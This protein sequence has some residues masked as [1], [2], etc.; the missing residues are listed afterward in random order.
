MSLV[1]IRHNF[2][3]LVVN[4]NIRNIVYRQRDKLVTLWNKKVR[5]IL[6]LFILYSGRKITKY[7]RIIVCFCR[8][9]FKLFQSSFEVF[10]DDWLKKI[11]NAV[12][13]K[14]L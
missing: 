14:S 13:F 12:D 11:I 5:F 8:K 9:I 1:V 4:V 6:S 10:F 3:N 2:C 7:F